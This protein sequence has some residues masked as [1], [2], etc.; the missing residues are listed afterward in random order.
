MAS[1]TQWT[2]VWA[3]SGIWWRTE[4]PGVLQSM[5]S[6]RVRHNWVTELT[7][8]MEE[9]HWGREENSPGATGLNRLH[10][11]EEINF[12]RVERVQDAWE[13]MKVQMNAWTARQGRQTGFSKNYAGVWRKEIWNT[14]RWRNYLGSC[15]AFSGSISYISVYPPIYIYPSLIYPS[16]YLS[17]CLSIYQGRWG[18][19]E[20]EEDRWKMQCLRISDLQNFLLSPEVTCLSKVRDQI[21]SMIKLTR[22]HNYI[23]SFH[24]FPVESSSLEAVLETA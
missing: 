19:K 18:S 4:K 24:L 14:S 17:T 23:S 15:L 7:D 10:L 13:A 16:I 12:C 20:S 8:C 5:G 22:C 2:W 3:S 6:Q 9:G 21:W 1:P 11:E